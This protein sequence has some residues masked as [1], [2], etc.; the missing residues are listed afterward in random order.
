[1]LV[2]QCDPGQLFVKDC[3]PSTRQRYDA[4]TWLMNVKEWTGQLVQD[5]LTIA[6]YRD[7]W[8]AL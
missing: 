5:L 6:Q 7:E 3:P 8:Q 4:Q 1:M 2:W